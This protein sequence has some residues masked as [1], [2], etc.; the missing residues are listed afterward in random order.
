M[1]V[2]SLAGFITPELITAMIIGFSLIIIIPFIHYKLNL[3]PKI[4]KAKADKLNGASL[5]NWFQR[6]SQNKK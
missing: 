2:Q 4:D 6:R 3:K 5:K 1:D